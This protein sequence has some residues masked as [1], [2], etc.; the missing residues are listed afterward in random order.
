M[1]LSSSVRAWRDQGRE[2][3]ISGRTVFVTDRGEGDLPLVLIHGFPGSSHDWAGLVPLLPGRVITLDLPGYG[4]SDK[5]FDAP[6]TLFD[7]TDAVEAVLAELGVTRCVVVGHDMGDTVTAELAHRSNAGELAFAIE[8]IILTNGSVFIDLA[9]LTRGQKLTLRLPNRP[10]LFSM[11]TV[12]LRRSLM[13]SFTR[14]APPPPGAVDDLIAMIKHDRGD[15]L[16][17]R[18]IRYIEERRVHQ[19]RW[20]AG[21]V[22]FPGPLTMVWGTEDPIAIL[23][24]TERMKALRPATSVVPL[25]GIGHWTS[26][27]APERLAA[28]IERALR[29]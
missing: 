4:F 1:S 8:Q 9:Q 24:M 15:R 22:D 17:P 5:G 6:Y 3:S 2:I 19:D 23:P 20:T 25:P 7:Q 27:E 26:I 10:S 14:T 12:I 18:L 11:P 29:A 28:E 21:F 16:M 13:E